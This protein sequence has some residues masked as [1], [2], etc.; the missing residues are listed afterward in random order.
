MTGYTCKADPRTGQVIWEMGFGVG[1]VDPCLLGDYLVF[2]TGGDLIFCDA[3]RGGIVANY[4]LPNQ[5]LEPPMSLV[6]GRL[7]AMDS[8]GSRYVVR[9]P[10]AGWP[11]NPSP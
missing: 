3:A 6:D 11:G 4:D 8:D 2:P 9:L 1:G 7:H 5:C 10:S